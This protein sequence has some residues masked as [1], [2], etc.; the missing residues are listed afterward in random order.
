[1]ASN[2]DVGSMP[3]LQAEIESLKEEIHELRAS[4]K[5]WMRIA[6]TDLLTKLPNRVY[7][8][9]SLLPNAINQGNAESC[10]IGCVMIAP[11]N[12]GDINQK[13]GRKAGNQIVVGLAKFLR[14]N[15]EEDE[16]L[17]HH[18][19]ANFILL[20]PGADLNTCKRRSLTIRARVSNNQFDCA[21]TQVSV[22]LSMGSVS[23]LPSAKQNMKDI[24]EEFLRRM[25]FAIDKAKEMG[26]D[27][28]YEDPDVVF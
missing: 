28:T 2:E 19:G 17:V 1:M 26:G 3:E 14:A 23:R 12:L 10:S 21:E 27:R 20:I 7:F 18:D 15:V 16:T 22:T 9:M 13:H 6:G 5:R 11:D 25:E 8:T 24:V 4:N